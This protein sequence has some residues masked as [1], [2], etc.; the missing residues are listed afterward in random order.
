MDSVARF[1]AA[2]QGESGTGTGRCGVVCQSKLGSPPRLHRLPISARGVD[3]WQ[4]ARPH[5]Q[6]GQA[7]AP[8]PHSN[9]ANPTPTKARQRSIESSIPNSVQ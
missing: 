4:T 2:G 1:L 5:A 9:H 6:T 8:A 7:R 3:F